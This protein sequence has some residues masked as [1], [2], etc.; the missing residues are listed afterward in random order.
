MV[1]TVQ[2]LVP[3]LG[4]SW[5]QLLFDFVDTVS[6]ARQSELSLIGENSPW[7]TGA[8][9]AYCFADM[10]GFTRP[11]YIEPEYLSPNLV[12]CHRCAQTIRRT[13]LYPLCSGSI[14]LGRVPN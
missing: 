4:G 9:I 10:P 1:M 12:R 8:N 14:C 5:G 6:K 11:R 2:R 7:D 13:K 3:W